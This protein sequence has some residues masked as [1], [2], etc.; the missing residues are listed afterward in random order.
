VSERTS[1]NSA[2]PP[3]RSIVSVAPASSRPRFGSAFLAACFVVRSRTGFFLTVWLLRGCVR[4][5]RAGAAGAAAGGCTSTGAGGETSRGDWG[6][7]GAAGGGAGGGE[8]RVVVGRLACG[9]APGTGSGFGVWE[10]AG[11]GSGAGASWARAVAANAAPKQDRRRRTDA[12]RSNDRP[13][14]VMKQSPRLVLPPV[15]AH[16]SQRVNGAAAWI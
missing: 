14:R 2:N 9:L 4:S 5:R 10:R 1:T 13:K 11:A 8:T 12:C 7:A 15:L 16:L 6:E 3:I